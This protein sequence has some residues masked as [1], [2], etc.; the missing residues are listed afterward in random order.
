MFGNVFG[1]VEKG[2]T[3]LRVRC[4]FLG[5]IFATGVCDPVGRCVLDVFPVADLNG[6]RSLYTAV[7]R[8]EVWS[9]R[10]IDG[11]SEQGWEDVEAVG[12]LSCGD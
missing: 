3:L 1:E 12:A 4:A 7:V 9:Q 5:S 8:D 10:L 11:F 6:E 2:G